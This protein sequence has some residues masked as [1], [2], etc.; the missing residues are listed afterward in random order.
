[1]TQRKTPKKK[2]QKWDNRLHGDFKKK[3]TYKCDDR[4]GCEEAI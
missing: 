2:N 3:K 4:Q 1:M